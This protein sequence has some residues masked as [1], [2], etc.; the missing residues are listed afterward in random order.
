MISCEICKKTIIRKSGTQKF[1][2]DCA[3]INRKRI[4]RKYYEKTS[5]ALRKN[6]IIDKSK[7]PVCHCGE[8]T[9]THTRCKNCKMLIHGVGYCS[10]DCENIDSLTSTN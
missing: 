1:C 2:I 6:D 10:K 5:I 3:K 7:Y 9:V 8:L 4:K